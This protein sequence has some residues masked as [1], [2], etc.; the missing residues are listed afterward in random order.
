MVGEVSSTAV[1]QPVAGS[2]GGAS[3]PTLEERLD[4][5]VSLHPFNQL[6]AHKAV[7]QCDKCQERREVC[8]PEETGPCSLCRERKVK[9]SLMPTNKSTG[10]PF[11]NKLDPLRVY[12]FRKEAR[13]AKLAA[14]RQGP[15]ISN[16]EQ[17][18]PSPAA[19]TPSP[20]SALNALNSM[21]IA[22]GETGSTSP[23]IAGGVDLEGDSR[24]SGES[25][26]IFPRRLNLLFHFRFPRF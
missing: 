17:A 19:L 14:K 5:V 25:G 11:R 21:S 10:R 12:E 3:L 13:D 20:S 16:E 6:T 22:G 4:F 15:N 23:S 1:Q 7:R 9:C 2:S 24:M 26:T 8:K 18:T